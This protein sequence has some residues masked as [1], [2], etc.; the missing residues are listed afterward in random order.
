M[1]TLAGNIILLDGISIAAETQHVKETAEK[2]A[3]YFRSMAEHSTTEND[4]NRLNSLAENVVND[5]YNAEVFQYNHKTQRL[6]EEELKELQI[7]LNKLYY[8]D[9]LTNKQKF[10]FSAIKSVI[11]NIEK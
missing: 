11:A 4:L 6:T 7:L 3:N 1:K 5:L 8:D 2:W 9:R 10:V